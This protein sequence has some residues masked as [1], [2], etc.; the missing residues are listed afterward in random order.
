NP[1]ASI[2]KDSWAVLKKAIKKG[3]NVFVEGEEDLMTIPCVLLAPKGYG[4]VYG[5]PG[6]GVSLIEVSAKTKIAFKRLL[7]KFNEGKFKKIVFGGTFDRLHKGHRYLILMAKYYAK[8]ALIGLTSEELV[9]KTKK[10]YKKVQSFEER[11]KTLENYLK[12]INIDYRIQR[13][14]DIYGS[15][16]KDK[17]LDAIL[18]TEETFENGTR[19]NGIRKKEGIRELD[20][21]ILPYIFD[22]KGK[23]ISSSSVRA[24]F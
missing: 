19:I 17:T 1:P 11:R 10:D 13:I 14:N 4:I 9:K 5:L 21:I 16:I 2:N 6:K 24:S 8:K 22:L 15:S 23:K 20:Y 3:E 18:L 7:K 12:K